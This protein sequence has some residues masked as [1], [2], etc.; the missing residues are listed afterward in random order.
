[1]SSTILT[2]LAVDRL[3][4]PAKGRVIHW[5]AL[6]PGFGL[7]ITDKGARSWIAM[8]RVNGKAVMQTLGPIAAIPKVDDA[9]HR[10]RE[11]IIAAHTGINPVEVRRAT[12][13]EQRRTFEFVADGYVREHVDEHIGNAWGRET[14]RLLERDVKPHW[15]NRPIREITKSD[16]NRLLDQ[17]AGTGAR[18]AANRLQAMLSSLF[19][20]AVAEGIVD[21]NPVAGLRHRGK[22]VARDR[23]LTDDE[24]RS[25]WAG[26]EALGWPF[27]PM[28]RLLLLTAQRRDEVGG[29]QWSELDLEICEWTIPRERAK[30]DKGSVVH[31]SALAVEIIKDDLPRIGESD[32]V[33][34]TNERTPV[35]GFSRAKSRLDAL[36]GDPPEW[37]LH[38]LRR[39]AA[40]GMARLGIAPHVVDRILGHTAGTIRGVAAVYNRFQYLPERKAALEAWSRFIETLV[41]PTRT[42]VVEL[43]AAR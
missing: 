27:G 12:Q 15:G 6:L 18:I 40:S 22:E 3:K 36:M 16:V 1:M 11:A 25:F 33:F 19:N 30:N 23:V 4:P 39:T 37:V 35:S 38:D 14:R 5:D 21:D 24:I 20:W 31:L 7:R 41:R 13:L 10:A 43:A 34:T 26:C 29:M 42:D 28:F 8:Y 9:R 32:L 17:K 2:Q